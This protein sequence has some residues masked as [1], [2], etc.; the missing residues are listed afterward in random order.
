VRLDRLVI[1]VLFVGCRDDGGATT[2]D[3]TTGAATT[4]GTGTTAPGTESEST[5]APDTSSGGADT[6]GQGGECSIWEQ[7]CPEA[8]KCVPWSL[9]DDLVPDDIRCCPEVS[10]PGVPGDECVVQ[11]YFGSCIDDCIEGSL[12]L[13]LDGDSLGVCQPFCRGSAEQPICEIDEGCFIYF[14]GVPFCFPRCDPLVQ[15]CPAGQGCYPGEEAVGGTD[16][17]CMPTIGSAALGEYCWLLSN[18]DP[19][20]ICVTPEFFPGCDGLVG[21]C[22]TMCDTS[23]PDPCTAI[24]PALECVSWYVGG[25]Q[26]PSPNLANVGACVIPP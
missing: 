13:D 5:A 7:D 20:L 26:P 8:E 19:G 17:L 11:D 9:E 23:E 18:C 3:E 21:C 25:Q 14:A 4:T 16:F 10:N 6:G 24:D 22:T 2:T 15:D 12:C 1:A